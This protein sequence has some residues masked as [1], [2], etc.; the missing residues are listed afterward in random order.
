MLPAAAAAAGFANVQ[1][2]SD[3]VAAADSYVRRYLLR[4]IPS[5]FSDL[6]P[7]YVDAAKAAALQQLFESY[8]ASLRSSGSLPALI[9]DSSSSS[10]SSNGPLQQQPANGS[11]SSSS[12]SGEYNPLTWVLHYLA[13]HFDRLGDQEAAL[14]LNAEALEL[15][16]GV[17]ELLLARARILKHTG[18]RCFPLHV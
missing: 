15:A 7:L 18:G 16:P 17:I 4:G 10:N 1:V 13:Q 11:S 3:F 14:R 2:G 12:G 6:K 5:L 8:A 9:R